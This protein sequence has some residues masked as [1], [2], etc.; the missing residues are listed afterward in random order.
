MSENSFIEIYAVY[1]LLEAEQ[2]K[3]LL[4]EEGLPVQIRDLGISPYPIHIGSFNEKRILV[5]ETD[6]VE[7]VQFIS[8]AIQD[9]IISSHGQFIN[10]GKS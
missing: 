6:K 8:R 3:G 4:E 1:D 10:Q 9:Q 2:V 7:A 5:M